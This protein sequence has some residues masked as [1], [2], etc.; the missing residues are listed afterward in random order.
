MPLFLNC[1]HIR[2]VFILRKVEMPYNT[3]FIRKISHNIFFLMQGNSKLIVRNLN[4]HRVHCKGQL[5]YRNVLAQATLYG[6]SGA[7]KH[8]PK[9]G[10]RNEYLFTADLQML[11]LQF[12]SINNN[13]C[14][15]ASIEQMAYGFEDDRYFT[16]TCS[17]NRYSSV[18]I[19]LQSHKCAPLSIMPKQWHPG[20]CA[21]DC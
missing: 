13:S 16:H 8:K 4:I 11:C 7:L 15:A 19:L 9:R 20:N 21:Q 2:R 12:A 1:I 5:F 17:S 3:S 10:T 18:Q 14:L 6:T